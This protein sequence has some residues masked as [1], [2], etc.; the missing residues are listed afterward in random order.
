MPIWDALLSERDRL[1]GA[2]SGYG[3]MAGLGTRPAV[4]VIDMN[5]AFCGD[6]PEPILESMVRWRNSCGSEAWEAGERIARV[7]EV[8]RTK[9]VPIIYTTAFDTRP[10]GFGSGRAPGKNAR[11]P[12][13]RLTEPRGGNEIHPPLAPR[14]Q[15]VV[16]RKS[17]P[18]AFFGTALVAH[19]IDLQVDSLI[20]C[21]TTTSG[22]VRATVVDA[23]SYDYRV[24]VME[25]GVFDRSESAHAM[26]LFDLQQKYADVIASSAVV[27]YLDALPA[28]LYDS[29]FSGV[30]A[31]PGTGV[32]S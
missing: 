14:P 30:V 4:L 28:G 25:D 24:A 29:R 7:L 22:C 8:A 16:L 26:N 12:E 32:R 13:D 17:R 20:V 5:V 9:R 3:K 31:D 15:D 21:G 11:R 18:S 1:V 19:L 2:R 23:F 6:R 10:D 27:G